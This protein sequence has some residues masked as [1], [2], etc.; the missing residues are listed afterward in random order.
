MRL[1]HNLESFAKICSKT[2]KGIVKFGEIYVLEEI[3]LTTIFHQK[4][5]FPVLI[6]KTMTGH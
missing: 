4:Y 5:F 3:L 2:A 1:S 6:Y